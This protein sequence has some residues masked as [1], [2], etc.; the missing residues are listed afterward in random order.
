MNKIKILS[1]N[2][3]LSSGDILKGISSGDAY[4]LSMKD[5]DYYVVRLSDGVI[6]CVDIDN[7]RGSYSVIHTK[8]E[9][10]PK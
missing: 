6:F 8:I 5:D 9:L 7:I 2:E 4:L 10:I 1:K 3:I